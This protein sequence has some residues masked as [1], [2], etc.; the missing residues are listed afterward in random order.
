V[1]ELRGATSLALELCPP[2]KK[3]IACSRSF[4]ESVERFAVL[5]EALDTFLT[6]ARRASALE[7]LDRRR[8]HRFLRDESIFKESVPYRN[9]LTIPLADP[10][11]L[12]KELRDW[13]QLALKQIYG[14]GFCT[15]RSA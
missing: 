15:N 1:E 2:D 13:T 14:D 7:T 6:R 8:R 4:G 5:R 10:S 9:S 3:S 11:N 12:T